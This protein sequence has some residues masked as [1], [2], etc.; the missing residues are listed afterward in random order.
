MASVIAFSQ[1]ELWVCFKFVVLHAM[2]FGLQPLW[3]HQ[4]IVLSFAD[5]QYKRPPVVD[6]S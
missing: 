4:H 2:L 6:E 3:C 5:Y 1:K